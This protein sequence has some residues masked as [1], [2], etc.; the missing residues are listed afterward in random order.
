MMLIKE[1]PERSVKRLIC[2]L[3]LCFS[4]S[5]TPALA[6][7]EADL[8][9]V[10]QAYPLSARAVSASEIQISWKIA[11]G[12]YLYKHRFSVSAVDPSV[13]LGDMILPPG[14]K[15]RDEFF[16]MWKPIGSRSRSQCRSRIP[17]SLA[18]SR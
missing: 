14:K 9:P 11:E 1:S 12:Y 7:S 5:M 17:A 16:G 10:E 13:S 15:Y 8:L 2:L 18:A 3:I 6:V 4:T